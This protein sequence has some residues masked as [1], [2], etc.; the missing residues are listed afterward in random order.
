MAITQEVAQ[1]TFL[2]HAPPEFIRTMNLLVEQADSERVII[3]MELAQ[4]S[5]LVALTDEEKL[6]MERLFDLQGRKVNMTSTHLF[7]Y[8]YQAIVETMKKRH[9]A[10]SLF[11]PHVRRKG[12]FSA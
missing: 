8:P 12:G 3:K 9:H 5:F 1:E 7:V 4:N 11:H 10:S 2:E 6:A